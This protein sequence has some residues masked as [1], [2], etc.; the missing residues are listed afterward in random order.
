[1]NDVYLFIGENTTV[2]R[3]TKKFCSGLHTNVHTGAAEIHSMLLA[4]HDSDKTYRL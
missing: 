4:K 1:V 3:C 2:P